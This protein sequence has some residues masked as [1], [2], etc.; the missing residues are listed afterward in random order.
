MN[1]GNRQRKALRCPCGLLHTP[2][3]RE[4][5]APTTACASSTSYTKKERGGS[6]NHKGSS[7]PGL[8]A[9]RLTCSTIHTR[10]QNRARPSLT[11]CLGLKHKDSP[12]KARIQVVCSCGENDSWRCL[13]LPA[14]KTTANFNSSSRT[15]CFL[16]A[17]SRP[18][19]PKPASPT[20]RVW[21]RGS[22]AKS[23][24]HLLKSNHCFLF[25]L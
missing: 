3:S 6:K 24:S 1:T 22:R 23:A 18:T 14:E 7:S 13:Q 9:S 5:L 8:G 10:R 11:L 21:H 15:V 25:P 4:A 20:S 17:K 2:G 12:Q 19:P 16:P